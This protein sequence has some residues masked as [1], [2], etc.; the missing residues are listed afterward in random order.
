[1]YQTFELV[2]RAVPRQSFRARSKCDRAP[3]GAE[4]VS[5]CVT[6]SQLNFIFALS[7]G[8]ENVMLSP[9]ATPPLP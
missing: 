5:T 6:E 8:T 4:I 1:M 9:P 3:V 7:T 2:L